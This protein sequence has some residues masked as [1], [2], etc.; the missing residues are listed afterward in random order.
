M[1]RPL[2]E[3]GEERLLGG[4]ALRLLLVDDRFESDLSVY[5]APVDAFD[6]VELEGRRRDEGAALDGEVAELA[7]R[8]LL[9]VLAVALRLRH[10]LAPLAVL[11][12]DRLQRA[13]HL[14]EG[15]L[16]D[17]QALELGGVLLAV[18]RLPLQ[19]LRH[20]TFAARALLKSSARSLD[21]GG[22]ERAGVVRGSGREA[23]GVGGEGRSEGRARAHLKVLALAELHQVL[24]LLGHVGRVVALVH[25]AFP[26]TMM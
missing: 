19:R 7:V 21:G 17:V 20:T 1:G 8:E 23:A 24:R 14:L 18:L 12:D 15:V 13:E 25:T 22:V 9:L 5:S 3:G 6:E 11:V 16:R 2:V 10:L 4:D 26:S